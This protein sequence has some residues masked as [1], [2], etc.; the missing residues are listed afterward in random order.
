MTIK[1]VLPSVAEDSDLRLDVDSGLLALLS[2]DWGAEHPSA[3]RRRRRTSGRRSRRGS[4]RVPD[5]SAQIRSQPNA[6]PPCGGG[7][8]VECVQQEA[9]LLLRLLPSRGPSRRTPA[10]GCRAD[11]YG[12]SRRRSRCRCRRCR[13]RTAS[14]DPG[15]VSKRCPDP[16]GAVNAWCTAVQAPAPTATSPAA[17]AT[18]GRLEQRRVDHPAERPGVLVDQPDPLGR[19]RA[20]WHRA[21]TARR[22]ADRPRR[23]CSRL[24]R[25]R[26]S[27]RARRARTR[28]RFL[29]TGPPSSP[30]SPTSTYAEPAVPALPGELLPRVQLPA[31]LAAP[32]GMTTAPT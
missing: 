20:A 19:S 2:G 22:R 1:N 8:V 23:R 30:S 18:L 13:T 27:R 11:G 3:G 15:S 28:T 7:A 21:A 10:P 5:S 24:A 9:E 26:R 12:S 6:I 29:A 4:S 16:A 14:A 31:R 17:I 25:H 32:P